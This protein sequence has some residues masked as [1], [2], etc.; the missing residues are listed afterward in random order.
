ML[1]LQKMETKKI[2]IVAKDKDASDLLSG[3]PEKIAVKNETGNR[4]KSTQDRQISRE[5]GYGEVMEERK[6][7]L[8]CIVPPLSINSLLM[9]LTNMHQKGLKCWAIAENYQFFWPKSAGNNHYRPIWAGK[10]Y[11]FGFQLAF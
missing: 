7:H 1:G 10:R 6:Y 9:Q 5:E 3:I 8:S 2:C 4:T 11:V